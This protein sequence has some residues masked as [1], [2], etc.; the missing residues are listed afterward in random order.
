M[1]EKGDSQRVAM[2]AH[3][4]VRTMFQVLY[5]SRSK[6]TL[7]LFQLF[8]IVDLL[9]YIG[10]VLGLCLGFSAMSCLECF[11]FFT[12]RLGINVKKNRDEA[13]VSGG[14]LD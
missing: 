9:S 6:I 5:S 12:I 4:Q 7:F 3:F 1:P 11:Y 2:T 10:G 13:D 8:S 14:L